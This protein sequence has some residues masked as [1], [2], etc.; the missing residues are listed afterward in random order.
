MR[1]GDK[2]AVI[3]GTWNGEVVEERIE[4]RFSR[5]SD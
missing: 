2:E 4:L 1:Y 3:I 5:T